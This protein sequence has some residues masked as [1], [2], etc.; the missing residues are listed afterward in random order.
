M[1]D[2]PPEPPAP[3]DALICFNLYA[4]SH[5]FIRL[6]QPHLERLG[7][8]YPQFLV[9]LTLNHR[10]GQGVSELG[11]ALSMESNTLSPLLKRMVAAGLLA[12]ARSETDERRV[13]ISLTET[14]RSKAALAAGVPSCI[15]SDAG[16]TEEGYRWTMQM[17]KALRG[18]IE[19]AEEAQ[20]A[21]RLTGADRS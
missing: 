13:V 4:A 20:E 5:A 1:S 18:M 3:T 19:Q 10:D 8:T 6:Y 21:A 17:L 12:R 7:L 11:Q 2:Q 9:L 16:L 15:A 14:G